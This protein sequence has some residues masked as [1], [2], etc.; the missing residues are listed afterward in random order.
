M[1]CPC[2]VPCRLC[3]ARFTITKTTALG[4][5]KVD[6]GSVSVAIAGGPMLSN[7]RNPDNTLPSRYQSG[8]FGPAYQWPCNAV[9]LTNYVALKE[10][11][12]GSTYQISLSTTVS[13]IVMPIIS[14]GSFFQIGNN[15]PIVNNSVTW[16]FSANPTI[17]S[18]GRHSQYGE[19]PN[20]G[21]C[22]Q[23]AGNTITGNEG[24]GIV[25]FQGSFSSLSLTV[26]SASEDYNA[27]GI[28]IP[29]ETNPLP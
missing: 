5:I 22:L 26:A 18:Q 8:F 23:V 13:R 20:S 2:C 25:D 14:L 15:P 6:G 7:E 12:A 17:I 1:A 3:Y 27:F 9:E 28:G 21:N 10:E 11:S 29:C 24:S 4:T 19:C 16:Q